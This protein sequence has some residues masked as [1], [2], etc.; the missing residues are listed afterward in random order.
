M[1]KY[2]HNWTG[3]TLIELIVVL[4]VL[5]ILISVGVGS[6]RGVFSQHALI[7]RTERLYH[8]LR[9][10][11]SQSI[12]LNKKIYVHFCQSGSSGTWKMAMAEQPS[13]DCFVSASC[14]IDGQEMVKELADG[15]TIFT[16]AEDVKF[17]GEQ[18]SYNP[19]RF[20][21]NAGSVTLTDT[22]GNKLKVIQS[23][24]RLKICSLDQDQLGYKKC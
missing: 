10:A 19:M 1:K 11:Q 23:T 20:S 18:A 12:K 9:L 2:L 3:F 22:N 17:F 15:K 21:V 5:A 24:K 16:S 4:A 6:Y 8:F 7:Q 14:L 13:C